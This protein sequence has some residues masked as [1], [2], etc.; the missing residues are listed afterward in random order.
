M[1][2]WTAPS[3]ENSNITRLPSEV[4]GKPEYL[5][6][7][8][9]NARSLQSNSSNEDEDADLDLNVDE[10]SPDDLAGGDTESQLGFQAFLLA[11]DDARTTPVLRS[12][13]DYMAKMRQTYITNMLRARSVRGDTPM[14]AHSSLESRSLVA[15]AS[16][17]STE[18]NVFVSTFLAVTGGC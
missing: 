14:P 18:H 10:R 4:P 11:L 12:D 7:F 1:L 3:S 13:P 6:I 15:A 8:D 9:D 5:E 2:T 17:G 16:N